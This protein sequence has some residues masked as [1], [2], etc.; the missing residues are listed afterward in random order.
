MTTSQLGLHLP[1]SGLRSLRSQPLTNIDLNLIPHPAFLVK[2]K[3]LDCEELLRQLYLA[4]PN[5]FSLDNDVSNTPNDTN[6]PDKTSSPSNTGPQLECITQEDIIALLHH[7]GTTLPPICPSNCPNGYNTK[8][9]WTPEKLHQITGCHCFCNY[10]HIINAS[11]DGHVINTGEFPISLGLYTV[12]PKASRGKAID[13]T[14]SHYLD[15]VHIDILFGDC[16]LIGDYKYTL[17]FV[18]GA[19]RYNWKL[20]LKSLQHEDILAAFLAFHDKAGSLACQF[21]CDCDKKLFGSGI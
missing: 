8:L 14:L 2:L 12:I 6:S 19:M 4:E 17:I 16:S 20:G 13:R 15:I 21:C 7:P 3:D 1:A 11:K 18:N 5:H 10:C 9:S